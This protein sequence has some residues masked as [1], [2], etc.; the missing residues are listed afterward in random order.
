[1]KWVDLKRVR[2]KKKKER[3]FQSESF[4]RDPSPPFFF[5]SHGRKL[6]FQTFL[7][8]REGAKNKTEQKMSKDQFRFPQLAA[9]FFHVDEDI[10]RLSSGK[11]GLRGIVA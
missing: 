1:M 7:F 11:F 4:G 6:L 5:S 9:F 8:G 10:L 3:N 2:E